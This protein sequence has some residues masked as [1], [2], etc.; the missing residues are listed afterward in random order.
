M[1]VLIIRRRSQLGF[2]LVE[3]MVGLVLG[4]MLIAG[5]VSI[6]LASKRSYVEVEQVA[7]LTENARFAEQL[8]GDSLRHAG[9]FGE[10]TPNRVDLDPDLDAVVNDC[11]GDAAAYDLSQFVFAATSDSSGGAIGCIT[12]AI[13]DTDVL[14]IKHA[15]PLAFSDGP[16]V[17][18]DPNNPPVRD[19][20]IDTPADL[21][22]SGGGLWNDRT[23]VMTNNVSGLLFDGADTAP[24]ITTGG[25]IP[26]G[27]AWEYQYEVFYIRDADVPQLARKYLL[28]NGS[29]MEV[30]T[31][32][33][34]EGVE[35]LQ[36]RFGFDSDG[37]GDVDSYKDTASVTAAE[38]AN[39][40]SVEVYMLV[41]SATGDAQYT[42]AK[43]Y[44]LGDESITP[45]DN[46]RRLIS[47]TSMSLRNLKI[48][49]RGGA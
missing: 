46:F 29:A 24:T 20:V 17:V 23:Y 30:E 43:T 36:L 32:N 9:F 31:E 38:W 11:S 8:V 42:D 3:L 7:A 10:V 34:A 14:V 33:L 41:R 22:P 2:S 28:W 26:G 21:L 44:T 49:M 35:N 45:N 1:G 19:G 39:I 40:Q 16:R 27:I 47:F 4:V 5:A 18:A 48:M 13:A 6:Y 25:E 37:D 15:L 12:D